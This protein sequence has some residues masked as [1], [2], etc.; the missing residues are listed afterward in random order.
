M[1]NLTNIVRTCASV[2]T[3]TPLHP[4]WLSFRTKRHARARVRE[5]ARGRLL[6]I[7]CADGGLRRH[8]PAHCEYVG[9]DYPSTANDL[10]RTQPDVFG[11]AGQLPFRSAAFD[12][13]AILDV[14][15][16][17]PDPQACLCE[18][19]RVL[20]PAG[21]ALIHVPYLYPLHD[22]PFDF[23][24]LT[25][26]GLRSIANKSGLRIDTLHH[27]G[28]PAETAAML[29]NLALARAV[30]RA[31]Q[32]FPPAILLGVLVAPCIFTA[33]CLGWLLGRVTASDSFMPVAYWLVASPQPDAD[34]DA[35]Q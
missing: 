19:H 25:E 30:L 13:V 3:R 10:Y 28:A 18:I 23:W 27:E 20:K 22:E 14:L 32:A 1:T 31:S 24:R 35:R 16:H 5:I 4:Q 11:D 29:T 7:G 26:H 2:L 12:T 6:D 17:V 33:N 9:L 34:S 15:E 21:V 8:L